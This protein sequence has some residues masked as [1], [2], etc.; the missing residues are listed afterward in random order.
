[1][2][3]QT[4]REGYC[5]RGLYHP[6]LE[7]DACGI[8]VVVDIKGRQSHQ[9]VD[10]ALKIVEKLEH[11]A[12]KD[13]QGKTGDGVGI[14]LQ[15]SHSFFSKAAAQCGIALGG[16]RDYGVGMFFFP[17][18]TLKR[19]QA[20]KMFEVI[21]TR[22]GME[23][24]GW[25]KVP[26][27]P[28]IL[29]KKALDKMPNIQQAFIRRPKEV[30][31]G[32]DFDRKLYITRRV[33]EQSNDNTYVPSLS[34]RT[35]VY[36]GMFLVGELR[37]FYLDLQD[38]DYCSA[39][40][41]V[42]SRFSTN[43]NPS[44]ERAH[45]YHFICHNGE[46]N[47]IRGNA[48][49]M[50]AREETL[51]S[52]VL[53]DEDMDKVLPV[54]NASGSDSAM[55]DNTLE[56]MVMS[57]MELPLAVMTT[58]PEP[59]MKDENISR[60]K[61]DLYQY[62]AIMMEPWD[63]P[64]S[65]LFSDGDTVGAV[66]D[67]NGLRPSRYY[68][69]DD[70]KLILS[71]EV[72]VLEVDAA[73]VVKK[74]HLQ[75]GKMLL[76][77]T[78]QGRIIDDGELKESYAARQPYGEWLDMGLIRLKDL[79]IPNKKVQSYT[80]EELTRLQKAFGYAYEDVKDTI[81]TMA[82][83]GAEP[84]GAMGSDTPL[85]VLSDHEQPLFNY[86]KQ[87]FAQVTNPPID[88]IREEVVTDT[89]VY[90]GNDGNLLEEK[91]E[92]A[93]A[94]QI[95]KPILTSVELMKIQS[96]KKAGFQV[97]TVSILYY[98]NTPLKR[99]LDRL[100]V[101]V[102][103]AYRH[104]AN[105]VILSDRGVDENHVA[106]PSLLAVSAVE[107]YLI[108]T[109]KSSAISI[110]LES[111][112][113]R[114]VQHFATLLGYGAR[115]VNPYLA[116]DT[117]GSLI[118]QGLLDKD[119]HTAVKDYNE[120]ILSGIVKIASKMGISTIQS[121]Q[122]AQI[123]EAV[124]INKDVADE[125][126]TGTLSR[127]GGV[128]L[129]EIEQLV[130]SNHSRAFDPLGLGGD[131]TLDSRGA[132]K[133]R[134]GQEDHM[135]SPEVIHLLQEATWN[136]DYELYKKYAALVDDPRRP[137]TLRG[138]MEMQYLD[139]PIPLDEVE[140]VNSIVKRFKTGAMSFGS[141]SKEAHECMAIAMNTLGGMSNSGEGGENPARF[142]TVKNSAIK[143][144]ASGRFGVTSEYLVSAQDIQIKMAQ[145][146]KPGEG[147]HLPGKKIT[148]EVAKTRHST[149]GVTLISPP[150]HHDI[151]SIEDLAQLIYDL[152]NANRQARISVK[153]CAE[154]GVG[155]IASGVAKAG[156]QVVLICGYDGGT[157]AAPRSS[158]HTAGVPWE[159]GVAETHQ[160]L[161]MNGLRS[162]VSV[163]VDGKLMSGRDV[164]IA[165]MLGAEEFGFSTAVLVTMGCVMMRVCNLGTCPMGIATQNPEL[166]KRFIGK[167]E[168]VINFMR[169]VAQDLRE[170]MARLGVRTVEELVGRT[171][172][173]KVREHAV[174]ERAATVDLSAI[175]TNH[176]EGAD[177]KRHF[178]PADV[179]DFELE[180][181]VDMKLRKKLKNVLSTGE[182][183][184]VSI[185]VTSTDRA[186]GAILGSDITRLHGNSLP[187]DTLTI[188]CTGGAGQ[189]F[190][191]F[192]PKGLT[193]E[194][195]G[196][197]ND[198]MGKGL[199]GGKIIVYPPKNAIYK[200]EENIIIGNVALYGATDGK[201]F[202]NG[203]A[204]ERFAVRNSGAWAVVEGVGDHGCEYMTGGRVVVLGPTGKNFAAGM[205]GG[206]AYVWDEDRDLYLR[207]NKALVSME[208]VTEKH[209][210]AEIRQ[211]LTEHVAATGSPKAKEILLHLD[212][213][214][215][216]FKKILPRDYDRML[217]TIAEFEDQGMSHE[218]AEIEAFKVNTKD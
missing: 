216:C 94:L 91:A 16:P 11:R 84:T 112:E 171:D 150:P 79:P 29:G 182:K 211:M 86:F 63:G 119:Y 200:P 195:E 117:I 48:D 74:S 38:D 12:G 40:A 218:Q 199:S 120:A 20:K 172:L 158:I 196:D 145:G 73:H 197:C 89:T 85:A 45:P 140:S 192:I 92:N 127:V 101:A 187:E 129:K 151:Y 64:S 201:A 3:E 107:R 102:D 18:D 215:S 178:D 43:T 70:E 36:K 133:V 51:H 161:I 10:D 23:F 204:G 118:S 186:L 154:P 149:P 106:I 66:L 123:F 134:A 26:I 50:L 49:R 205:S 65:I 143:Q 198:H 80:H 164:A 4:R 60:A 27:R 105:I 206:I 142:G 78:I 69:T 175:L 1:M 152:K 214:A 47:T 39:I 185:S 25:R 122:S 42:H 202:I 41:C 180:K 160:T 72:G 31:Q 104:G 56:F 153:L 22:E 98:K 156:A 6:E 132:H 121:Y 77:D 210:I 113:P 146:A 37:R 95:H 61:R 208:P 188:K 166:R 209:D 7:H 217:C 87:L 189:S 111:A 144:V 55:L 82:R 103:R 128:G 155:T 54:I 21:V 159:L 162:R 13:A 137:H 52:S 212:E 34:S 46:I 33:F 148:P 181:T 177:V 93:H 179:F 169:F 165:C 114:D 157:G 193:L 125:Y 14:L 5:Q 2:I 139:H 136:R 184:T 126:F 62:Y 97:E 19:N 32:L 174:N 88:A 110:V 15:V 58:I 28:E 163:E 213:K 130:D 53:S 68:I 194:L 81:L 75:P 71:S 138:L 108:R 9:T 44:W 141:I 183:K 207:L 191:A 116:H 100:F 109:K 17:Q 24:L 57:G 203:M 170:H 35:I 83:T 96:M 147:G 67:R 167:P 90:V 131:P 190:G 135:Y 168:Y 8:G 30:T 176:Y 76:V 99:A 59:W 115:A 173:L 124:G